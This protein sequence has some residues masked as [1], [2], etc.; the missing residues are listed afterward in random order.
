LSEYKP[1]ETYKFEFEQELL[2]GHQIILVESNLEIYTNDGPGTER[3]TGV[4]IFKDGMPFYPE[5]VDVAVII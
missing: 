3:R 4:V 5:N 2:K 1:D